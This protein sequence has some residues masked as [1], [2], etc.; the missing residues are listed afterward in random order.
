MKCEIHSRENAGIM[1]LEAADYSDNFLYEKAVPLLKHLLEY[2]TD[3]IEEWNISLHLDESYYYLNKYKDCQKYLIRCLKLLPDD[4]KI[5]TPYLLC[6]QYLGFSFYHQSQYGK[7]LINLENI[8]DLLSI[9]E[10]EERYSD[11]YLY[12]LNRGRTYMCLKKF[13]EAVLDF[14]DAYKANY[15]ESQITD[16]YE[17]SYGESLVNLELSRAYTYMHDYTNVAKYINS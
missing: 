8:S 3:T 14:E 7:A 13:S 12:Y 5:S 4:E 16:D 2:H 17:S 15:K 1:L 6:Y 9:Y 10:D 11:L